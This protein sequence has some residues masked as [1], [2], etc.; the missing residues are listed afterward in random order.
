MKIL[1]L[2]EALNVDLTSEGICTVKFL[3][4]LSLQN[5]TIVCL[6]SDS[7]FVDY[8]NNTIQFR[9]IR[10]SKISFPN[11]FKKVSKFTDKILGT[12]I[13]NF[14]FYAYGFSFQFLHDRLNWIYSIKKEL[15]I[16]TPDLIYVRSRGSSFRSLS[17]MVRVNTKIPWIANYHDPFPLSQYPFPYTEISPWS[18]LQEREN[19]KILKS[20]SYVFTP[21]LRLKE[22]LLKFNDINPEKIFVQPHLKISLP[23]LV[24]KLNTISKCDTQKLHLIHAG[25]LLGPRKPIYFFQAIESL[26]EEFPYLKDI[27]KVTF[28]GKVMNDFSFEH[29]KNNN[30]LTIINSRLSYIET[31]VLCKQADVLLILEAI[32]DVSPFLPGKL[33]DYLELRK[34]LFTLS[35]TNSEINRLLS[36]SEIYSCHTDD[37]ACIK[38]NLLAIIEDWKCNKL[39]L[40][41]DSSL[42][43]F[44]PD[45]LSNNLNLVFKLANG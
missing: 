39:R 3:Y 40:V 6:H 1:V 12:K 38:L 2:A 7:K 26:I 28:I 23:S 8:F 22:W 41:S 30:M 16:F 17:A 19:L 36:K 18:S 25:S 32:S 45:Y 42:L 43:Y 14:S 27:I 31:N 13:S 37:I 20:A 35:P 4:A 24:N 11:I 33:P 9:S 5:H 29:L 10:N 34:P 21:S 15:S 44:T